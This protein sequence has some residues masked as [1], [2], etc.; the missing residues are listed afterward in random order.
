MDLIELTMCQRFLNHVTFA[1]TL[2]INDLVSQTEKND[3]KFLQLTHPCECIR[4]VFFIV[5]K[6]VIIPE[7]L[8]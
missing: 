5:A 3:Q 6:F 2:A 7:V 4:N 8:K 1:A